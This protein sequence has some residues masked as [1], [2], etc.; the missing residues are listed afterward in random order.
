MKRHITI[1]MALFFT[2]M[3]IAQKKSELIA[4][5]SELKTNLRTVEQELAST[6][7]KI[8]SSEAKAETLENENNALRD[9]NQT[10]L[11]NLSSFSE[12]S[13]KNSQNVNT[14]LAALGRKEK[15][16][17]NMTAMIASNDSVAIVLLSKVKQSM[18]SDAKADF[19]EGE[20]VIS[21]SLNTLFGADNASEIT[22]EGKA[23]LEKVSKVIKT[24]PT[25]KI[26]VEGL[27]ITGEFGATF[28]QATT[29]S[30]ELVETFEVSSERVNISVK[31]GNFKEGINIKLQPDY[32]SFY[33][34]VKQKAK[35]N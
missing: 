10:L 29:I 28:D 18:G 31:D 14:T 6:K 17:S 20:I 1:L 27:N 26:E 34:S 23:W 5:I 3:G 22:E 24:N 9:A 16:L 35:D 11:Q 32:K 19:V 12:L 2:V 21:N 7:R 15:Q 25:L 4:E 33:D 30:K 8:S 13:K